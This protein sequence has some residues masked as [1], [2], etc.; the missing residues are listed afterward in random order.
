MIG[1]HYEDDEL[2][3]YIDEDLQAVDLSAVRRHLDVCED[4]CRERMEWLTGFVDLLR[5][6]AIHKYALRLGSGLPTDGHVN[7]ARNLA[8]RRETEDAESKRIVQALK[9]IPTDAW[10]AKIDTAS[11]TGAAGLVRRLID[12]ARAQ[13]DRRPKDS[14]EILAAAEELACTLPGGA[15]Q[16]E[17]RGGI[18]KER[19]EALRMLGRH[20]EA[21]QSLDSAEHFVAHLPAPAID[22]AFIDWVRGAVLFYLSRFAEAILFVRRAGRVF[23]EHG[24]IARASQVRMIEANILCEQ[25]DVETAHQIFSRLVLFF[26]RA[27]SREMVARLNANLAECEVRLD[28]RD[29]AY[30]YAE[31]AMRIY[32]ELGYETEKIRVR[33]ILGHA[34]MRRGQSGEALVE[35][36]AAAAEF[37]DLEMHDAV[38][39]VGLDIVEL[40]ITRSEWLEAERLAKRLVN[41]FALSGAPLHTARAFAYLREAAKTRSA[42][43]ELLEYLRSYLGSMAND[44]ETTFE[45]PRTN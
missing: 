37:S 29:V 12:E 27:D 23:R 5:D 31:E 1:D 43:V 28:H 22:L 39:E 41:Q 26:G 15:L 17:H 14:L 19:A 40:H 4:D 33:W 45:P 11:G 13:F 10:F 20:T 30:E 25:G 24:D 38:A 8:A 18:A 44:G 6:K 35:L 3:A 21:L 9:E 34:L 32:E 16:A 2:L 42:T 7:D 36:H